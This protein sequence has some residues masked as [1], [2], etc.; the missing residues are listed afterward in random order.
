LSF[1]TTYL[2]C[3]AKGSNGGTEGS[4]LEFKSKKDSAKGGSGKGAKIGGMKETA[5]W[6]EKET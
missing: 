3:A 5:H 4:V 6:G 1:L 2:V